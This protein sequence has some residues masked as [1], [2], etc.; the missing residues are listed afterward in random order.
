MGLKL[1][2]QYFSHY[3][4]LN[5]HYFKIRLVD[6]I[7][8]PSAYNVNVYVPGSILE[9]LVQYIVY[10]CPDLFSKLMVLFTEY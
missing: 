10:V 6:P 5:T 9:A 8:V 3:P 4:L 1:E 2:T 7:E